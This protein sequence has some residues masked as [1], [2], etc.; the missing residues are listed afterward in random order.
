MAEIYKEFHEELG[1]IY[2]PK[3]IA[4]ILVDVSTID[5]VSRKVKILEFHVQALEEE[6]RRIDAY[7]CQLPHCMHFLEDATEIIK[8]EILRWKKSGKCPVVE[9]LMPLK[10]G[11]K[12][13][14]GFEES[15]DISEKREWMRTAKLWTT[16]VQYDN[17]LDIKNQ[18]NILHHKSSGRGDQASGS[19]MKFKQKGGASMPLEKATMKNKWVDPVSSSAAESEVELIYLNVT[20]ENPPPHE[21][22]PQ[23]KKQ[24]RC[25]SPELHKQFV[26]AL[27]QLGGVE[28]A[29]PKQIREVMNFEGLTN[30]EVK[31]HLQ[32]YRLHLRK[33]P[34]SARQMSSSWLARDNQGGGAVL[35]PPVAYSNTSQNPKLHAAV[36]SIPR[37]PNNAGGSSA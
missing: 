21:P 9:E 13:S 3:T 15:K 6:T 35:M 11:L 24:R 2:V 8:R 17:N 25:W 7:N 34:P 19:G 18:Y 32:K 31:S 28:S 27:Q 1:W 16:P 22:N 10:S 33:H 36:G 4:Q 37:G 5:D 26:D 30:D 14:I 20:G 23:P 29:T 12:S